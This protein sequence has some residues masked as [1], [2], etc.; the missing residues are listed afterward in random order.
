MIAAAGYCS[1]GYLNNNPSHLAVVTV[2]LLRKPGRKVYK[3]GKP[4]GSKDQVIEDRAR[5]LKHKMIS[6]DFKNSKILES[7]FG[8]RNIK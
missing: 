1:I 7:G 3:L 5:N 8:E 4:I 2:F 6:E